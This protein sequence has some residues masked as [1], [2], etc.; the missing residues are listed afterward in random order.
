MREFE[1]GTSVV[2]QASHQAIIFDVRD[3]NRV[4]DFLYFFIVSSASIIEKLMDGGQSLYDGLVLRNLAVEDPQW[5]RH[6]AALAVV[7]H[8]VHY[9]S[10]GLAQSL[11]ESR[12][13]SG[14]THGIQ[15]QSP[16]IDAN[17]VKQSRK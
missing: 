14:A 3:L 4:Q 7:A 11:A 5:I 9:R 10:Q 1:G 6:R 15:F 12:P 2:I 17:A 13:V 8:F 16:V